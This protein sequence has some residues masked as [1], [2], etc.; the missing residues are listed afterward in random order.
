MRQNA[1]GG[2]TTKVPSNSHSE[3]NFHFYFSFKFVF[4][5]AIQ[6]VDPA[7]KLSLVKLGEY[8]SECLP[9]YIQQTQ[10]NG[11]N[12][13]EVLI[14]PQGV[15][16]VLSFLKDNHRTQFHGFIDVTAVDVPARP[17]RF[18]VIIYSNIN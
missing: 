3:V 8:I 1:A 9:K 10:I 12:E 13:L 17:Y 2:Q 6:S 18:E 5:I 7:Q 15:L 16:P 11:A 4:K 14:H